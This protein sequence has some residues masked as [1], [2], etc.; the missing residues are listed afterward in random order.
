MGCSEL[1]ATVLSE[2]KALRKNRKGASFEAL[3]ERAPTICGLLSGGDTALAYNVLVQQCVD[4]VGADWSMEIEAA[5]ASLGL[6][7]DKQTVLARLEEF[8]STWYLDQ[9]QARRYSDQGL[10]GMAKLIASTWAVY[11]APVIAVYVAEGGR[12][13][14]GITRPHAHIRVNHPTFLTMQPI[15]VAIDGADRQVLE[16]I[17]CAADESVQRAAYSHIPFTALLDI[18]WFGKLWPKWEVTLSTEL[19]AMRVEILGTHAR[20]SG[21]GV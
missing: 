6:S 21:A 1:E 7:N 12:S 10:A 16:P 14:D 3:A 9:R 20:I 15:Q 8:A 4:K 18:F 11:S 5:I 19:M 17:D 13:V 2:L